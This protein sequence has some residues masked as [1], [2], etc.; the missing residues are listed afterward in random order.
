MY[1]FIYNWFIIIAPS[2]EQK[3]NLSQSKINFSD[4]Q[5]DL[6]LYFSLIM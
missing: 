4:A 3:F 2:I 1:L 5:G 6:C